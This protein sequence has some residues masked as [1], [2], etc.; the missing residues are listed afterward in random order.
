LQAVTDD[1]ISYSLQEKKLK[2]TYDHGESWVNTPLDKEALFQGEYH[3]DMQ[4]L[5]DGSYVLSDQLAAFI[6]AEDTDKEYVQKISII[7]SRD[8]GETWQETLV[9]DA[10]P[11]MRFRKL[12]FLNE[13]FAYLILSG[14]RT[15]S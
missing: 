4:E 8:Q 2:I 13:D 14:D 1:L 5:I 6:Y 15:M 7:Y 3:G 10:F 9:T 11:A 12:E